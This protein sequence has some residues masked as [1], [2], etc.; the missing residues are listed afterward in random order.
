MSVP[1]II[2]SVELQ[3]HGGSPGTANMLEIGGY[4]SVDLAHITYRS[5]NVS[6]NLPV[7]IEVTSGTTKDLR[8]NLFLDQT[9]GATQIKQVHFTELVISQGCTALDFHITGEGLQDRRSFAVC[10]R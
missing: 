10:V 6:H 3:T 5:E 2:D 4:G 9:M 7:S 8:S 1:Y